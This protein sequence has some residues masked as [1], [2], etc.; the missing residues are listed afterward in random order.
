MAIFLIKEGEN[1]KTATKEIIITDSSLPPN[2]GSNY[3]SKI[4][5]IPT[6]SILQSLSD[7]AMTVFIFNAESGAI[8]PTTS[9]REGV[10]IE[11]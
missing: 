3:N 9:Y 10:W 4:R 7:N 5:Y 2:N 11:L 1:I 8:N 6:G